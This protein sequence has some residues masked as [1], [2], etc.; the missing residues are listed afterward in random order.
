MTKISRGSL[1]TKKLGIV[2]ILEKQN[3]LAYG[4]FETGNNSIQL[5]LMEIILKQQQTVC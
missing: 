5:I 3:N 2:N 4:V 1:R